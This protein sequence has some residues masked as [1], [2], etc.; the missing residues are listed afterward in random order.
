VA[1]NRRRYGGYIV[2][3]GVLLIVIGVA[4]GM[5]R[6]ERQALMKPG[7]SM[8]IE[9][10]RLMYAGFSEHATREKLIDEARIEVSDSNGPVT[11]L[12]PQ[13]NWH[14]AERQPQSEVAISSTPAR[15][16][17]VVVTSM[18]KNGTAAVRAFVNPLTFWIWAGGLVVAAGAGILLSER[19][20][21]LVAE[22]AALSRR[23]PAVVA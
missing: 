14:F 8:R 2:H 19:R 20:R 18:S 23:E 10:Y 7:D 17:Y 11:T 5:F 13:R 21:A 4:G 1:R 16:I 12:R 15:D 6:A 22:R 9:G 3:L